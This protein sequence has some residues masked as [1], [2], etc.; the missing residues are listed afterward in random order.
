[1]TFREEIRALGAGCRIWESAP[2]YFLQKGEPSFPVPKRWCRLP[3]SEAALGEF[4]LQ[5]E[6][7]C[8]A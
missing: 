6:S 7:S 3:N 5:Y 2:V 1:M 4:A 8:L